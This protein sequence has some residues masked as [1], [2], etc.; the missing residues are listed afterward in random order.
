MMPNKQKSK[1]LAAFSILEMTVTLGITAVIMLML[2]N[3]LV[4]SIAISQRSLIRS[5]VREE[6]AQISDAIA[7]DIK[8]ANQVVNCAGTLANVSCTLITDQEYTWKTCPGNQSGQTKICKI[9][10]KEEIIYSTSENLN[11]K[12]FTI[13]PGFEEGVSISRRNLLVTI[14]ADHIQPALGIQNIL[15]QASVSTRNY[16]L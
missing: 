5:F 12:I 8:A 6:V 16:L 15:R 14:S 3:V 10:S 13:E 4:N 7:G 9:N 2:S 1:T 11:F